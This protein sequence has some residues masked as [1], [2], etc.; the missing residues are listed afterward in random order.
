M[1]TPIKNIVEVKGNKEIKFP[2]FLISCSLDKLCIIAPALKNKSA[3][4]NA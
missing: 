3:L 2:N 4:K 1:E